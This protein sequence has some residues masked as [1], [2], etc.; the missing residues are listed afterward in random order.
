M[1]IGKREREGHRGTERRKCKGEKAGGDRTRCKAKG[2][3][4]E[5]ST[6]KDMRERMRKEK[7]GNAREGRERNGRKR[8]KLGLLSEK[9]PTDVHLSVCKACS[10]FT[11]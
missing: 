2:E 8:P 9:S 5:K 7:G 6:K 10:S 1:G 3:H 4:S 11:H